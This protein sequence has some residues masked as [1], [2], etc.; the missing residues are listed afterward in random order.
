MF[1]NRVEMLI[2]EISK[3]ANVDI[4]DIHTISVRS[5]SDGNLTAEFWTDKLW[6]EMSEPDNAKFCP[7]CG[8][9]M[10]TLLFMG[11]QPEG[12]ICPKCRTLFS[13]SGVPTA[14]VI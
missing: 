13:D 5:S 8:V 1:L 10:D 11:I 9:P 7:D 3:R 12:F 14:T 4:A 2:L 6:G